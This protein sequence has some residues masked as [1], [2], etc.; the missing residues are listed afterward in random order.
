MRAHVA[1][2]LEV[3]DPPNLKLSRVGICPPFSRGNRVNS[4]IRL[5]KIT[6]QF[7]ALLLYSTSES[8]KSFEDAGYSVQAS[9]ARLQSFAT[10]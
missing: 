10:L 9:S 1:A 8:L 3:L 6:K 2:D 5:V 4:N 7:H